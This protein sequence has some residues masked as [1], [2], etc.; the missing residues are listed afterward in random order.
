ML[1]KVKEEEKLR[2][3]CGSPGFSYGNLD[4]QCS[5]A[6]LPVMDGITQCDAFFQEIIPSSAPSLNNSHS[7]QSQNI[8][9]DGNVDAVLFKD[10]AAGEDDI[11]CKDSSCAKGTGNEDNQVVSGKTL[12]RSHKVEHDL[13]CENLQKE[14]RAAKRIQV[15]MT[16][17]IDS[18]IFDNSSL[19]IGLGW[20]T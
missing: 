17:S 2:L 1:Q 7:N 16:L 20:D 18:A 4:S 6:D 19:Y 15:I 10:T 11:N 9:S 3:A 12:L 5:A 13:C 14:Q 8:G